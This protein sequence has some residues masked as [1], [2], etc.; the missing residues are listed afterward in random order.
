MRIDAA[1]GPSIGGFPF[2]VKQIGVR[3]LRGISSASA[4]RLYMPPAGTVETSVPNFGA[5]AC[6]IGP[7]FLWKRVRH[8]DTNSVHNDY[9][10][11]LV[12]ERERYGTVHAEHP[13]LEQHP[14]QLGSRRRCRRQLN[15]RHH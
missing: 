2:S 9:A 13:Q 10:V 8:N 15:L 14:G 4:E 6:A 12:S 3:Q 7:E 1:G 5:P 11:R